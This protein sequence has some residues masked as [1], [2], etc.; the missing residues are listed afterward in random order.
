MI[1]GPV[2]EIAQTEDDETRL[3]KAGFTSV[4]VP[5][6]ARYLDIHNPDRK[7][8]EVLHGP[9]PS[10][11]KYPDVWINIY[12]TRNNV[13]TRTDLRFCELRKTSASSSTSPPELD[14]SVYGTTVNR[15]RPKREDEDRSGVYGPIVGAASLD[16]EAGSNE[17]T[18]A[19]T[20]AAT[21]GEI[22]RAHV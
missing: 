4:R 10:P 1:F 11:V 13:G 14:P 21:L 6:P 2:K 22:G 7:E 3:P 20:D 9:L 12:T 8:Y 18:G 17:P 19:P 16:R 5:N 15:W